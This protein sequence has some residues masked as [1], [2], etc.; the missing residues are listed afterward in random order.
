VAAAEGQLA[1]AEDQA[2]L[3]GEDVPRQGDAQA[4][5]SH[6][7]LTIHVNTVAVIVTK[8]RRVGTVT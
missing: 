4:R 7:P 3:K 2:G 5:P 6:C 1:S 8:F